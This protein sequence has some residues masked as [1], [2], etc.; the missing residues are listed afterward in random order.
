MARSLASSCSRTARSPA[1]RPSAIFTRRSA[2]AFMIG[3]QT[4]FMQKATNM[5]NMID[6]PIS[7][8]LMFIRSP[9]DYGSRT[10]PVGQSHPATANRM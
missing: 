10:E 2:S 6:W 7:V 8:R 1:A 4:T 3:G 5:K 9:R